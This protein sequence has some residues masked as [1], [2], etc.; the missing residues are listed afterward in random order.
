MNNS[1]VS[2]VVRGFKRP[3]PTLF[4]PE[5]DPGGP[6]VSYLFIWSK[7]RYVRYSC[8]YYGPRGLIQIR[9]CL[10]PTIPD[11][12]QHYP[13][14]LYSVTELLHPHHPPILSPSSETGVHVGESRWPA[15]DDLL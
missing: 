4:N 2:S 8:F 5:S 6:S 9:S 13:T 10:V 15:Q 12:L 14:E 11:T 7:V 3:G 1:F